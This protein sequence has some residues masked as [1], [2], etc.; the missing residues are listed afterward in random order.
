MNNCNKLNKVGRKKNSKIQARTCIM[1]GS[2]RGHRTGLSRSSGSSGCGT[3]VKLSGYSAPF[4]D[5]KLEMRSTP[6]NLL[7]SPLLCTQRNRTNSQRSV[8]SQPGLIPPLNP[9]KPRSSK[10]P[11]A[12]KIAGSTQFQKISSSRFFSSW[13]TALVPTMRMYRA[14]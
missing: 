11:K 1:Q 7:S 2:G 8:A 3:Y 4:E 10:I 13:A 5:A 6:F 12:Y 14:F 9:D